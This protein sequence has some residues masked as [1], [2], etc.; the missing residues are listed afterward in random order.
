M[1]YMGYKYKDEDDEKEEEGRE[2]G[3]WEK[4]KTSKGK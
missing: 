2:G 1:H 4:S 3:G